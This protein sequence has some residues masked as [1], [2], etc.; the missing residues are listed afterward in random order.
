MYK[1]N[2]YL[3]YQMTDINILLYRVFFLI[4]N[5]TKH[6]LSHKYLTVYFF[7]NDS[8]HISLIFKVEYFSEHFH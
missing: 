7:F 2:I 6:S 4:I 5:S 8:I 1:Q 3:F